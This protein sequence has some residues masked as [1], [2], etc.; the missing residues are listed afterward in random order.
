MFPVMGNEN[1]EP[2]FDD[3]NSQMYIDKQINE[4]KE[5]YIE[6]LEN[7]IESLQGSVVELKASLVSQ[8]IY[9]NAFLDKNFSHKTKL[10]SVLNGTLEK[11][12]GRLEE[13]APPE[14]AY[15]KWLSDIERGL[16]GIFTKEAIKEFISSSAS[17]KDIIGFPR[18]E[19]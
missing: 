4:L 16:S 8:T 15:D 9:F 3:I 12:R 11:L 5:Y 10:I 13:N 6:P 18:V 14:E 2:L 19:L 17:W 7:K 1:F